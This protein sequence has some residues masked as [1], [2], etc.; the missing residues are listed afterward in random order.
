MNEAENWFEFA[1]TDLR[2]AELAQ[3][4]GLFNQAC[5]MPIRRWKSSSRASSFPKDDGF[6][7]PTASRIWE[8]WP[9]ST[10]FL[11]IWP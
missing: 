1:R 3:R 4:D 11:R 5:S 6:P 2:V 9:G 10:A 8:G 7:A